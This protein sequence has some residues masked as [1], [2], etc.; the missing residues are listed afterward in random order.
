MITSKHNPLVSRIKKYSDK[1][2]RDKDDV[3]LIEGVK[4]VS[5][6]LLCSFETEIIVGTEKGL[7]ELNLKNVKT[8]TV[9][10]EVFS[11]IS[12]LKTPEGVIAIVKKPQESN[13]TIEKAVLLDGVSDP[14]NVG[15]I[16]RTAAA[17]GIDAVYYTEDCADPYSI[18]SVRASMG[19]IFRVLLVK[20]KRDM[21]GKDVFS[22]N[23]SQKYCLVVGNEGQGVSKT[24]K[25]MSDISVCV[26]MENN[27]ESLNVAV[28]CGI[29]LYALKNQ[30]R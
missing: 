30:R 4:L 23:V 3:Y 9:S 20:I 7:N 25:E 8:E 13:K 29:I 26:P 2:Y 5:D 22:V 12:S 28:S 6:C 14:S 24:L 21:N 10:E 16:L 27:V 15:A 18:K 19:G 17:V 1:K 11:Y